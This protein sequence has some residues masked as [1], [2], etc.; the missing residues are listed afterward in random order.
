MHTQAQ[1][2]YETISYV[3]LH[4]VCLWIWMAS[5]QKEE[6][7]NFIRKRIWRVWHKTWFF[8]LFLFIFTALL[9]P[10]A[11]SISNNGRQRNKENCVRH[12]LY[13]F[14]YNNNKNFCSSHKGNWYSK[15]RYVFIIRLPS[16]PAQ[17]PPP[18][19]SPKQRQIIKKAA[20]IL[21]FI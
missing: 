19:P 3:F 21:I 9:L 1:N 13:C 6:N 2:E 10:F 16:T 7:F 15:F 11:S 8:F 18:L 17:P 12:T 20:I 5:Y 4:F 14:Y